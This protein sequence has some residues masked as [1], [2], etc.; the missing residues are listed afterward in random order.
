MR[1]GLKMEA[2]LFCK[3]SNN[4]IEKKLKWLYNSFKRKCLFVFAK[5]RA[6]TEY[7]ERSIHFITKQHL[8]FE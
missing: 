8:G 2:F 5:L 6:W 1:A 7:N 3:K 4:S